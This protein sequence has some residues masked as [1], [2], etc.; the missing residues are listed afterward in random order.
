LPECPTTT[1]ST[2]TVPIEAATEVDPNAPAPAPLGVPIPRQLSDIL[3]T[4]RL[5]ESG[6]NYSI[7]KNR[8]G[9][10]GA[11]QYIDSTWN[12][13]GGFPSAY[14]APPFVQDERALADVQS[15]LRTWNNDVSM[16]P[17]IWY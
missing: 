13:Y 5:V 15:I 1:S 16:V 11:Y 14:L 17:V 9:A 6:N 4:I 12:N 8:G 3:V 2:T 10:S 7:T